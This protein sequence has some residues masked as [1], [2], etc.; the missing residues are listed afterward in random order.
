VCSTRPH[1]QR[2]GFRPLQDA[3][4]PKFCTIILHNQGLDSIASLHRFVDEARRRGLLGAFGFQELFSPTV[5]CAGRL[6]RRDRR[7]RKWK[8]LVELGIN[9]FDGNLNRSQSVVAGEINRALGVLKVVGLKRA[10]GPVP[11][12]SHVKL[13]AYVL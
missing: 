2:I 13:R 4:S 8:H 1:A 11:K 5:L 9:E 7:C 6:R 3:G 10:G 12:A